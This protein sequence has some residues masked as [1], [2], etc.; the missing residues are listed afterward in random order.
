MMSGRLSDE[1]LRRLMDAEA[2][3]AE[4]AALEPDD[5][6]PLPAHVKVSRPNR[7]NGGDVQPPG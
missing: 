7:A 5:G 4:A 2:A 3:A 1:E 6:A